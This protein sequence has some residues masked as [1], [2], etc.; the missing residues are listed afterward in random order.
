M[1]EHQKV[2][3]QEKHWNQEWLI[4]YKGKRIV[5]KPCEMKFLLDREHTVKTAESL[6]AHLKYWQPP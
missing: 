4:I 5:S 3:F 6:G 2:I 1:E